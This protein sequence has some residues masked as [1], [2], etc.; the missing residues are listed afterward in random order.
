MSKNREGPYQIVVFDMQSSCVSLP[1]QAVYL[2]EYFKRKYPS[3]L[4]SF[5]YIVT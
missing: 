4:E 2:H 5:D 3:S 1:R